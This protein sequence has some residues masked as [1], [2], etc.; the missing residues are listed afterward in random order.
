VLVIFSAMSYIACRAYAM[1]I[2]SVCL[3]L[4]LLDC[5]HIMQKYWKSARQGSSVSWLPAHWSR[6]RS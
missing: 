2:M 3:C 6:P 4:T 5:D 1:S